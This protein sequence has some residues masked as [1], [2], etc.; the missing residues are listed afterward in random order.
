MNRHIHTGHEDNLNSVTV[1]IATSLPMELLRHGAISKLKSAF[2]T[3][4][5]CV[6]RIHA[7]RLLLQRQLADLQRGSAGCCS[8]EVGSCSPSEGGTAG[9]GSTV[10]DGGMEVD[11]LT[12][13]RYEHRQQQQNEHRQQQQQQMQQK[14][15][16]N[17]F[18]GL[19]VS[20]LAHQKQH[21]LNVSPMI[22][23]GKRIEP[24]SWSSRTEQADAVL[25]QL[26]ALFSQ[27]MRERLVSSL[28]ATSE[29]F[30]PQVT[31]Y[32]MIASYPYI[33][34]TPAVI[35]CFLSLVDTCPRMK[36]KVM[37]VAP[38]ALMTQV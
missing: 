25:G 1:Q 14:A 34:E 29:V 22:F 8:S 33:V 3:F 35:R 7:Q 37:R 4:E 17:P 27:E 21:T 15:E 38:H 6:G 24:S 26:E 13:L 28:F 20:G 36:S 10:C 31:A 23:P 5:T 32:F 30:H 9:G 19:L 18:H 2:S 12:T 11:S 16:A